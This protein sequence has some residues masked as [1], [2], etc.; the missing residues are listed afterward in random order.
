VRRDLA[1]IK[2]RTQK[3]E[4]RY[5]RKD[6]G[7]WQINLDPGYLDFYKVVLASTK[8]ASQRIYI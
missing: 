7:G 3:I 8:N 5:R 1:A 4:E 6:S 2:L